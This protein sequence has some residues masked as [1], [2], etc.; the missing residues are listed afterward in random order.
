MYGNRDTNLIMYMILCFT[1]LIHGIIGRTKQ[2]QKKILN[3]D[4]NFMS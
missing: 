4:W 1:I 3:K 2:E